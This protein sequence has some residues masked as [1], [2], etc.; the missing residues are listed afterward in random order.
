MS[1]TVVNA[2][3]LATF[4]KSYLAQTLLNL[5]AEDPVQKLKLRYAL[6]SQHNPDALPEQVRKRCKTWKKDTVATISIK[7]GQQLIEELALHIDLIPEMM[8]HDPSSTLAVIFDLLDVAE[9]F[10]MRLPEYGKQAIMTAVGMELRVL[11]GYVTQLCTDYIVEP[12]EFVSGYL[13]VFRFGSGYANLLG[14]G[15][16]EFLHGPGIKLLID[17][18]RELLD[19]INNQTI[20]N[21]VSIKNLYE[22][23]L[24]KSDAAQQLKTLI[25]ELKKCRGDGVSRR[26]KKLLAEHGDPDGYVRGV[27]EYAAGYYVLPARKCLPPEHPKPLDLKQPSVFFYHNY[28]VA[29]VR[30]GE[31]HD[32]LRLFGEL[33]KLHPSTDLAEAYGDFLQDLLKRDRAEAEARRVIESLKEQSLT[34]DIRLGTWLSLWNVLRDG[35]GGDEYFN[36]LITTRRSC[37]VNTHLRTWYEIFVGTEFPDD[38]DEDGN[39]PYRMFHSPACIGSWLI[40]HREIFVAILKTWE[41]KPKYWPEGCDDYALSRYLDAG[42]LYDELSPSQRAGLGI[43]SHEAWT[44][45]LTSQYPVLMKRLNVTA[46]TNNTQ[47]FRVKV[48][49]AFEQPYIKV[50]KVGV[51]IS[52]S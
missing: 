27:I 46:H 18:A 14:R 5:A 21:D 48:G 41:R 30:I 24:S 20:L 23:N 26:R 28:L 22:H 36:Q 6:T 11:V 34:K 13:S 16:K 39:Y 51:R 40:I 35:V 42:E 12:E 17:R 1:Q 7:K 47:F 31:F 10:P 4:D 43:E 50:P 15:S 8:A 2:E 49:A 25:S 3:N 33:F 9:R 32:A 19:I 52:W 38:L 29:L 45:A 44:N 37:I